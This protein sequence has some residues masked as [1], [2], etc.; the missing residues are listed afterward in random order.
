M[1]YIQT[2]SG[3]TFHYFL[4]SFKETLDRSKPTILLLHPRIFDLHVLDPQLQCTELSSKYNLLGVDIHWHGKTKVP[5][6]DDIF[7][8]DRVTR[9]L[10]EVMDALNVDRFHIFGVQLGAI[11]GIRMAIVQPKRIISLMLCSTPPPKEEAEN[12]QQYKVMR[13]VCRNDAGD[14][15]DSIPLEIVAAGRWIYFGNHKDAALFPEWLKTS[16]LKASNQPYVH[17]FFSS[18][19]YRRPLTDEEWA[20]VTCPVLLIHGDD[21]HVYPTEA[22]HKNRK[23]LSNASVELH[24]LKGAP[25]FCS[26]THPREVNALCID[27]LQNLT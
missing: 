20:A 10:L 18:L 26:Y 21:D 23:M 9:E 1:P 19:I 11:L 13:E 17:K 3:Y 5:M 7:D 22:A 16:N 14:G 15:T 6:D 8:Y 2:Q 27:F 12:V 4:P 25:M 24:I